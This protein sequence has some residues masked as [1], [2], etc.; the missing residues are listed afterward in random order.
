V[1]KVGNTLKNRH[2]K[3]YN[4]VRKGSEIMVRLEN[5]PRPL[6]GLVNGVFA[7]GDV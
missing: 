4:S 6:I 7:F 5:W 2:N 1:L 3:S